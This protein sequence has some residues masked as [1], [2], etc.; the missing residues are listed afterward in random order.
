M[1]AEHPAQEKSY[2]AGDLWR[3]SHL[4]E[5]AG[6][7]LSLID[8][9][10]YE[11]SPTGWKHGDVAMRIGARLLADAEQ[12]NLGRVTAAETGFNLAPGTTLAPDVGFIAAARIPDELPDGYVPF[13][14]DLAVEVVSPGNTATEVRTKIE[15]YIQHGTRL[16]WVVYPDRAAVDVY[17]AEGQGAA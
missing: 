4:P 3:L 8:G 7:R 6:K 12:H 16:V 11:M 15:K 13:A 2:T 1:A 14:P 5:N 17:R 10:I 9:E